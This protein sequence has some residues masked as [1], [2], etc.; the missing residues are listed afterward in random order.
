MRCHSARHRWTWIRVDTANFQSGLLV[1]NFQFDSLVCSF[2]LLFQSVFD[3]ADQSTTITHYSLSLCLFWIATNIPGHY[4][5][6]QSFWHQHCLVRI[7]NQLTSPGPGADCFE[8]ISLYSVVKQFSNNSDVLGL[9]I[10]A[11]PWSL[12]YSGNCREN[13]RFSP[14]KF[15]FVLSVW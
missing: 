15:Y 13:F 10:R 8:N 14:G 12:I 2:S 9:G 11:K 5:D 7:W 4:V 3:L 1:L 6:W